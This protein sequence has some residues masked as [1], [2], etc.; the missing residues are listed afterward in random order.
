MPLW[1]GERKR[2]LK[3]RRLKSQRRSSALIHERNVQGQVERLA[4]VLKTR[5]EMLVCAESCTGGAVAAAMTAQPG[6]SSW[7]EAGWVTYS[8]RAKTHLLGVNERVLSCHGAV[9]E[10][11]VQ[12]MVRGALD[13]SQ[14][15]W[16]LAISGIAGPGGGTADKPVG[17]V[18]IA[19][20]YRPESHRPSDSA[21]VWSQTFLFPGNR[22]QVQHLAV[23]TSL[24]GLVS[25]LA[26]MGCAG[27]PMGGAGR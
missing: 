18:C 16:A 27:Q 5:G 19:W 15:H 20:A 12:S 9:S 11:V 4:A 22:Q 10:S 21:T 7:F 6:A 26:E 24:H 23:L 1:H 14:A 13:R 17:T 3:R 8:N 25:R 2:A